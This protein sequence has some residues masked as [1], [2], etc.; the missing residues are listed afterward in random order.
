MLLNL[1]FVQNL[2]GI[3]YSHPL[4]TN[5]VLRAPAHFINHKQTSEQKITFSKKR[6][7][8]KLFRISEKRSGVKHPECAAKG[9]TPPFT[10]ST[11]H[12]QK[13]TPPRKVPELC[14][15]RRCAPKVV[16]LFFLLSLV[17]PRQD[18]I[19]RGGP[20]WRP[21][22]PQNIVALFGGESHNISGLARLEI[23]V[24]RARTGKTGSSF[25]G[26]NACDG[27]GLKG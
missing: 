9:K 22:M 18:I 4:I 2:L 26:L 21:D 23:L 3:S 24:A 13:K 5:D 8:K 27:G 11:N 14:G 25:S 19:P 16:A 10:G 15:R 12:P 7:S 6:G 17:I 20:R 1:Q